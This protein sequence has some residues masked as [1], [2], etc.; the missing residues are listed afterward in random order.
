LP[1]KTT[2]RFYRK[3]TVTPEIK[4]LLEELIRKEL[5]NV[6]DD[7]YRVKIEMSREVNPDK[8]LVEYA[9]GKQLRVYSLAIAL[10]EI[11]NL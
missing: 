1:S 9:E 3:V 2:S 7:L 10:K 5:G 11:S 8:G 4:K 6:Q